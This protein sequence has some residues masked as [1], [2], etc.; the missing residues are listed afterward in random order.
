VRCGGGPG[1]GHPCWASHVAIRRTVAV[2]RYATP[3]SD[4]IVAAKVRGAS[5]A[6]PG[7]G[8]RVAD[9]CAGLDVDLVTWVPTTARARRRRGLDHARALAAPIAR[10]LDVPLAGLLAARP[11]PDQAGRSPARRRRLSP[12]AFAA[13][14]SQRATGARVLLVDDVLTTGATLD[15]ASRVLARGLG[16]AEVTVAVLARAGD[17]PLGALRRGVPTA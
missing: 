12:D 16:A 9:A 14:P 11:R 8:E 17:H 2:Y 4:A 1:E 7:L 15:I 10:R 3:V 13:R 5:G 6:W